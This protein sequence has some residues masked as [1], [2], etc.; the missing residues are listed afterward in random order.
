MNESTHP[1][2]EALAAFVDGRLSGEARSE[3]VAH[4]DRCRDCYDVFSETVR[5]Q[6]EEEPRGKVLRPSRLGAPQWVWWTAAAAA[7][8]V[9]AI[10]VPVVWQALGPGRLDGEGEVLLKTADLASALGSA[11]AGSSAD[12]SGMLSGRFEFAGRSQTAALRV[13]VRLMDLAAA[14]RGWELDGVDDALTGLASL[15]AEAEVDGAIEDELDMAREALA[16]G[17]ARALERAV[18]RLEAGAEDALDPF[19]LAL[20]KWAEAGRLAAASGKWGY[21]SSPGF[22]GFLKKLGGR[23]LPAPEAEAEA[24]RRVEELTAGEPGPE[25]LRE[26]KKIF[27]QLILRAE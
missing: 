21:F 3:M 14:A 8:L 15:V 22:A 11:G 7:V 25:E 5:F 17:D 10:V 20:G 16:A 18:N 4:L 23:E 6:G 27:G 9:V 2:P 13:G 26:L 1:S 12:D 24:V 19:Y